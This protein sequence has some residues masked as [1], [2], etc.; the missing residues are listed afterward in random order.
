MTLVITSKSMPDLF[1]QIPVEDNPDIFDQVESH[2]K[3][4]STQEER[5]LGDMIEEETRSN[6][7]SQA[8]AINEPLVNISPAT[9]QF[10]KSISPLNATLN[11]AVS[12]LP[13]DLQSKLKLSGE[14]AS[15]A[16]AEMLSGMT[17]PRSIA[18]LPAFLIPGVREAL[19]LQMA[20]EGTK[21][22]AERIG[23][24]S[25][26]GDTKQLAKG[27]TEFGMGS[28]MVLPLP[29][30]ARATVKGFKSLRPSVPVET[31]PVI[32]V[33]STVEPKPFSEVVLPD[34]REERLPRAQ[35]SVAQEPAAGEYRVTEEATRPEIEAAENKANSEI[36]EAWKSMTE[37]EK[38]NAR[39]GRG[40]PERFGGRAPDI[41][42]TR[43]PPMP[44]RAVVGP[45]KITA[46]ITVPLSHPP[47][48]QPSTQKEPNALH[49]EAETPVRDVQQ[50]GGTPQGAG[51]VPLNVPVQ[52]AGARSGLA[53][54][55]T[56]EGQALLLSKALLLKAEDT[57]KELG[58]KFQVQE[59]FEDVPASWQ[60]DYQPTEGKRGFTF[61]TEADASPTEISVRFKEK[62]DQ[63][64]YKAPAKVESKIEEPSGPGAASASEFQPQKEFVTS[65]KNEVVDKERA[66]RGLPPAMQPA[67]RSFGTVWDD[68]TK[69]VDDDPQ[70]QDRLTDELSRKPRAVTDVEDALMLQRQIDL[71]NSL[72][73]N[74]KLLSDFRESGNTTMADQY[75]AI[76]ESTMDSLEK[77][78]DINKSIGTETARGLNARKMLANERYSLVNMTL[79]K[80]AAKEGPLTPG[81][82][83]E[84]TRLNKIISRTQAELE[85]YRNRESEKDSFDGV[86]ELVRKSSKPSKDPVSPEQRIRTITDKLRQ[87]K[88]SSLSELSNWIRK[89][90]ENFVRSGIRDR[91]ALIDAVH[92]VLLEIDPSI[93][94]RKTMDAISGYG[95]FKALNPDEI[96]AAL[97]D[98]KGQMQQ[99]AKLED[100]ES[101]K[102]LKKTG[103]ER[104]KPSNEERR[105]IQQVNEYK[106]RYGV[107]VTDPASQLKSALDT[108]KTRLQNQI[109][110]LEYQIATG[111]KIVKEK[112]PVQYDEAANK[113]KL[114]RDELKEQFDSI[115]EKPGLTDEQRIANATR[116]VE[117]SIAEY[118]RRLRESDVSS[119]K[120]ESKTPLTPEL[121][122]LR[123]R[124][125]SLR[126]EYEYLKEVLNPSKRPEQVALD[127]LKTRL[128][129]SIASYQ[130]RLAREDFTLIKERNIELDEEALRLKHENES[131]KRAFNEGLIKNRLANRA[132]SKKIWGNTKESLNLTRTILTS[133]DLSALLRQGKFVAAG[134]PVIATKSIGAMFKALVS[135]KNAFA[136][137]QEILNRSNYPVYK[138]SGLYLAEHGVSLDKMEEAYM[139]RL[140]DRIP[141]V[142]AS[143][144]AYTTFLNRLRADTFDT[145]SSSLERKGQST[146]A[147]AKVIADYI[148]TATGRGGPRGFANA[149]TTLNT[150]F[151]AP[152]YV[153]S[154]FQLLLGEPMWRGD[155]VTRTLVAKEYGK[156]LIGMSV[157]YT[158]AKLALPD[159]D[160][161]TEPTSSDY[162]KLKIGNTRID[163]MAG[164]QQV[165]VLL[166]REI[167]GETTTLKGK[168]APLRGDKIPYGGSTG[169]DVLFN[170]LRTKLAPV[171][172]A[173]VN[174]LSGKDVAG[175]PVDVASTV[176]S[177]TIP[178]TYQDILKVMEDQGLPR[179]V[180]LE[181]LSIFGEGIQTYEERRKK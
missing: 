104:R 151:F 153:A 77:V 164:L 159:A 140:A 25:V 5:D 124:R 99:V 88:G 109:N 115:F 51:E 174:F 42:E 177:L 22:G 154:R 71:Q 161:D 168:T 94:R 160:I 106:R 47:V 158:L 32:P 135:E 15:E 112:T 179:G 126:G 123:R 8:E 105:L 68:A 29:H 102:P 17:T 141:G 64:G 41:E 26:T 50:P 100:L 92:N 93:T 101:K 6:I 33:E 67:R 84:I 75:Q 63:F 133:Y 108:V 138:Q 54:D 27:V 21:A 20:R 130:E 79:E 60:F 87:M 61:Y 132:T 76:V 162:L 156:F 131:A 9:F 134:H 65:I 57:A 3:P 89:L 4:G 31:P 111:K 113:L 19:M 66:E 1:D 46:P 83:S 176:K 90:A 24:A 95:D 23:E 70:I 13:K 91:D 110:D 114:R 45:V 39:H 152:R 14:G 53:S 69:L 163:P 107:V 12:L 55:P 175:N 44:E 40:I 120:L 166:Q 147:R 80:R 171:P 16:G 7:Q 180:A 30:S 125:E 143:Q 155:A 56:Q 167:T 103:V 122:S 11:L 157:Y 37:A 96:K 169:A 127:A 97:R 139:S 82:Q 137:D 136:I 59:G 178:I 49:R 145:L 165:S 121:E 73:K 170:F 118:E 35:Q 148:N 52:E 85:T 128:K 129:N 34:L 43:E 48:S 149:A 62:L 142:K 72:E 146:P 78:Y 116:A 119:R 98:L 74:L 10:V 28:A 18:T 173:V 150:V 117:S 38:D 86:A 172:G 144:R 36:V 2:Y 58:L 81:E 181:I